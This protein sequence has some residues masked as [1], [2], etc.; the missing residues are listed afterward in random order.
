MA[1]AS[2]SYSTTADVAKNVPRYAN[3]TGNF[4]PDTN[5]NL[6]SVETWIDETSALVDGVLS[7]L[8]FTIPITATQPKRV[9]D[10]IVKDIVTLRVE[11]ARGSGRYAPNSK[12]V[13]GHGLLSLITKDIKAA[14]EV[15]APA[16]ETWGVGRTNKRGVGST[17]VTRKDAYSDDIDSI[18]AD[19]VLG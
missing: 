16:L 6:S 8:G 18:E 12:A 14:I 3:S 19:E 13:A 9:M 15:I 4:D 1:I 17:A 10:S 5:P 7:G 11:G 2:G